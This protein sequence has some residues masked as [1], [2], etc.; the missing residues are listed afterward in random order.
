MLIG[1]ARVSKADGSQKLDLQLDALKEAGVKDK[2]IFSDKAS[3]AKTDR[4]GL[5]SCLRAL[6][7]GDTLIVWKLDRLGRNLRHM[8]NTVHDLGVRGIG[9]KVLTG[10]GA[11]IDTTTASGKFV[12]QIF[13]AFAEFDRELIRERTIA[14]IMAA[15]KRGRFGGRKLLL[16]KS[17]V[18]YLQAVM[19]NPE[20]VVSELAN[21]LRITRATIYNYVGPNGELR[22]RGKAI[23]GME[24][25][26]KKTI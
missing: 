3:G 6:R 17:Q 18:R 19:A 15:R 23:L 14:G 7:E 11:E 4:P 10:Q 2:S 9:F 24:L 1:Y 16:T 13:A 8:V 5:E 26:R 22:D 25:S 20:T 12:F 21:E